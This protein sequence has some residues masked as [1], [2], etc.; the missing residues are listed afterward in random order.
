MFVDEQE[1]TPNGFKE[2][3]TALR[4]QWIPVLEKLGSNN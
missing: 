3:M 1:L 4:K 2:S